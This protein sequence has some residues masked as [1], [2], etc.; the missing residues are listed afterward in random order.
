[1]SQSGYSSDTS[2][3]LATSKGKIDLLDDDESNED[4]GNEHHDNND[5]G[6]N[7]RRK[8]L[9]P[10]S[11]LFCPFSTTAQLSAALLASVSSVFALF[12]RPHDRQQ[13]S[14]PLSPLFCPF[15]TTARSSAAFLAFVSS[16]FAT[17]RRPHVR[18]QLSWPLS[19]LFLPPFDDRTIV[20]SSPGLCLLFVCHLL[21]TLSLLASPFF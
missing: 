19:S 4:D 10:L 3:T 1:M 13:L 14:W 6:K 16:V 12:R 17:F 5:D 7:D 21:T 9:W 8:L 15:L 11:P 18:R 20:G 2:G